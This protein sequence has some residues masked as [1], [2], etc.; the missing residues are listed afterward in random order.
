[1]NE[2]DYL[3]AGGGAAGTFLCAIA[4]GMGGLAGGAE[5][6]RTALRAFGQCVLDEHAAP[7]LAARLHEGFA[8]AVLRVHEASVAVPA[9][10]DMGTTL[11]ALC[12][13]GGEVA[14]GHVGD[15]R[16]YRLQGAKCEQISTDHAV[17]QPENL[18]TRCIGAGQDSV[19]ADVATFGCGPNDRFLLVTDGVW[20]VLPAGVLAKLGGRGTPQEAAEALVAEALAAGGPDNATAVVVAVV[21]TAGAG[22]AD[23]ALPRDERPD[24]RR[25]WPRPQSLRGPLWP[26]ALLAVATVVGVHAALRWSG[27]PQGL[28]GMLPGR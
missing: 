13:H 5:A 9:L 20:S 17:R 15:T 23:V 11:T 14:L 10:R 21:G 16:A 27:V 25:A 19:A 6:S 22:E 12:F 4:D 26:W 24:D 1:G 28:F 3:L 8:A 18:L 2:D 7:A